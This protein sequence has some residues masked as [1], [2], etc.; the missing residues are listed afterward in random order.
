MKITVKR[1]RNEGGVAQ[2]MTGLRAGGFVVELER[3]RSYQLTYE[4]EFERCKMA[5]EAILALDDG[6]AL[7]HARSIAVAG[8]DPDGERHGA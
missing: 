8:L 7:I 1:I 3:T 2:A 4:P 6:A 5:L